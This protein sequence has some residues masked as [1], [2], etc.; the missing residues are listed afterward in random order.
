MGIEIWIAQPFNANNVRRSILSSGLNQN[1]VDESTL[2]RAQRIRDY[3]EK[4]ILTLREHPECELKL[5]W[6]RDTLHNKAEFIKD[7]Q[8]IANSVIPFG[9]EKHLV[10]GADEK[11][12]EIV[13]CNHADFDD[14]DIRQL[15][16]TYLDPV[17]DFEVLRLQSSKGKDFVVLRIPHQPN[18]PFVAKA[19]IR[20]NTRA[21][22]E[23]G[24]IWLKPGG[25]ETGSS[26][27]RLLKTR[28][29]LI[30]LIDIQPR[31]EKAIADMLEQRIPAI[32]L[33][34]RTRLQGQTVNSISALASSDEEF[35]SHIEQLLTTPGNHQL[36]VLSVL[37]EKLREKTVDIWDVELDDYGINSRIRPPD[38]LRIKEA[39]FLPAMRRV[40]LLGLLLIKFSVP[41]D[42]FA[43]IAN[44]L[45]QIFDASHHLGKITTE[46]D[47]NSYV[48]SLEEHASHTVP[49]LESL[50]AAYLLAGF[51]LSRRNSN[52]YMA[53]FFDRPVNGIY[54]SGE[55]RHQQFFMFWPVTDQWGT[56]PLTRQQLVLERYGKS[57]R[58]EGIVGGKRAIKSAVLQIDCLIDWHSFLSFPDQGEPET[59]QFYQRAFSGVTTSFHP[60]FKVEPYEYILPL[61]NKLWS[62]LHTN[63]ENYFWLFDSRL[64][65]AFMNIDLQRRK[66]TFGRFLHYSEKLQSDWMWA[67]RRFPYEMPWPSQIMELVGMVKDSQN[68][69]G[70]I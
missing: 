53:S 18:R 10:V 23:E 1:T 27:K 54:T 5:V 14:A 68:V 11:S 64:S 61:I 22:L 40:V 25:P 62:A 46:V 67:Q 38:I 63:G 30:E 55:T 60:N 34:E 52:L 37:V 35:E 70:Q 21:F 7:I 41:Q 20:D 45:L 2:D 17:P 48:D 26:G 59:I 15:L 29:E 56:P 9:K 51:E 50:I 33:E 24:Q 28:S 47:R 13:G 8:A 42:W 49:A 57:D 19:S 3:V 58:I 66:N 6:R 32:R 65:E 69:K 12:K 44:L 4:M 39:E 16:E 43:K 31:V 36:N